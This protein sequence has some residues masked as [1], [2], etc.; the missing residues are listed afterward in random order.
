MKIRMYCF[1]TFAHK[2]HACPE[3]RLIRHRCYVDDFGTGMF[4]AGAVMASLVSLQLLLLLV[5]VVVCRSGW[6]A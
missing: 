2:Q 1:L 3:Q 4:Q 6:L 5:Q